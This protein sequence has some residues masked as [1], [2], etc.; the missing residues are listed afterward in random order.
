MCA[1]LHEDDGVDP[2]LAFSRRQSSQSQ[3]ESRKTLQLC[4]QVAH[5]LCLADAEG[6]ALR[7]V[8]IVEVVPAPDSG[9]LAVLVRFDRG[10]AVSPE[11][12]MTR[13]NLAVGACR[14]QIAA[15]ITRKRVP[16]LVFRFVG[17][18]ESSE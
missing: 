17:E 1:E 14:A 9:R 16:D 7:E 4:K 12:I 13:L 18:K 10:A 11:T 5:A 2:R 15:A 6:S 3:R 8:E